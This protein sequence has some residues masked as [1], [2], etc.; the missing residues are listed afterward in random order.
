MRGLGPSLASAGVPGALGDPTLELHDSSGTLLASDDDWQDNGQANQITA[1]GVAPTS[2]LESAIIATLSPGG[3][4]AIVQGFN[5]TT[6]V[7]MV[8]VYDLN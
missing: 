5:A 3:Y 1:T 8:E 7:G 2:P 4:T 6:G